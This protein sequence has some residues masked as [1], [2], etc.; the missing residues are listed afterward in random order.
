MRRLQRD[1]LARVRERVEDEELELDAVGRVGRDERAVG[2][3]ARDLLLGDV[4]R[5]RVALEVGGGDLG[6]YPG[7]A[8]VALRLRRDGDSLGH[9]AL[10]V[11]LD[12]LL[13]G[14]KRIDFRFL[15]VV[16]RSGRLR[17]VW[18]RRLRPHRLG[19]V[20]KLSY[21]TLPGRKER[22]TSGQAGADLTSRE[23]K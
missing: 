11:L 1:E 4:P 13:L 7:H 12:G 21:E 14:K 10:R 19:L 2:A 3:D 17:L 9:R 15:G 18:S 8:G 6:L 22:L 20:W 5:Q 16:E 23:D